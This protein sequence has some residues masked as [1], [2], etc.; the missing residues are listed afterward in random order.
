MMVPMIL[1]PVVA[2]G[3]AIGIGRVGTIVKDAMR[4]DFT[5]EMDDSHELKSESQKGSAA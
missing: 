3:L 4:V 2:F 1:F 5:T